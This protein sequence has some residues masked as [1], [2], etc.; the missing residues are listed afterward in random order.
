MSVAI[1]GEEDKARFNAIL[2]AEHYLGARQPSGGTVYQAVLDETG[3]WAAVAL[4]CGA[5]Y[6]LDP[7]DTYIGWDVKKRE[8]RLGLVV[9]APPCAINIPFSRSVIRVV[10]KTIS[11]GVTKARRSTMSRTATYRAGLRTTCSK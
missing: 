6:R 11:K 3:G 4:W 9:P 10:K 7:R 8:E 2:E 5:S 1:R